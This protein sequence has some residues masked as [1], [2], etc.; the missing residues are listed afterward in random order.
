MKLKHIAIIL[1]AATGLWSCGNDYD[2]T[3]L[4]NELNDLKSRV[5]K[6]EEWSTKTNGQISALQGAITALEAND[7]VTG[8][9]P[10]MEDNV[11]VGYTIDFSKSGSIS[12][13][14]GKDGAQGN[15]GVTPTIGVAQEN[16]IY[17]WTIKT[18]D[19]DATWMLDSDGK[20]IPTT[21]ANG[22]DGTPGTTPQISVGTFENKVYWK[23]NG[24]WLLDASGN[25]VQATG[26]KGATG[27]NGTNGTPGNSV[28]AQNGVKVNDDN[29]EFTLADGTTKFTLP[30]VDN[31]ITIFKDFTE[32][33]VSPAKQELLLN[34]DV[35]EG[36]YV[37]LKAEL[38]SSKGMTTGYVK[39]ATRALPNDAPWSV[40]LANP[41]F[42]ADQTI[43]V[44]AKVTFD[45]PG[46]VSEGDFALLKI[47]VVTE[48]GK[49]QSATRVIVY[50][51]QV[52]VE[53]VEL[54]DASVA[55]GN[56]MQ[57]TPT[58]TPANATNKK[59]TWTSSKPEVATIAADGK[60]TGVAEG[61]TTITVTTED[62]SKTATCKV[63]VTA[64]PTLKVTLNK[65]STTIDKEGTE[66]LTAAV[67]GDVADK[68]VT[69]STSDASIATVAN[70]VVTAKEAGTVTITATSV[71]DGTVTGTCKVNVS[72]IGYYLYSDK[73]YSKEK[74]G[75]KIIAGVV[76]WQNPDDASKGKIVALDQKTNVNWADMNAWL[77]SKNDAGMKWTCPTV[78][79]AQ[80]I[81]CA[82]NGEVPAIWY[83]YDK[84]MSG[85]QTEFT[86]SFSPNVTAQAEFNAKLTD[87][88][89]DEY[90][91]T[92][93][94]YN[95]E[96]VLII[97]LGEIGADGIMP[98]MTNYA[99]AIASY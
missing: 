65:A 85:G 8:V 14:S 74:D 84:D 77:V 22:A 19:A 45:F 9:S 11:K 64:A 18:G 60:V 94:M 17:Y 39:A 16:G 51:T 66:T 90:Y 86:P 15:D 52:A 36:E 24:E 91:F 69:W 61:E 89:T 76:F 32:F 47:T 27:E 21:G 7:Y 25:K 92:S 10:I 35:K 4:K 96:T 82:F 73:S 83:D 97:H 30:R 88:I 68:S 12:I 70:G 57:L 79:E 3:E 23:I 42:K 37:A 99:R 46:N 40:A 93:T 63:T 75:S 87:G 20:K 29:V 28:F 44:N 26:D 43:E 95:S 48:G 81:W 31:T 58:F 33:K 56:T 5:E 41:T 34:L 53:K 50:T 49:E 59:V 71:A 72:I 38:T 13:F 55:K 1:L 78:E 80:Y 98:N 6:L 2:D 67:T 54:A 62:G